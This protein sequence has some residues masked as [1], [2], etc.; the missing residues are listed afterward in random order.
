LEPG[1]GPLVPLCFEIVDFLEALQRYGFE[2]SQDRPARG[3]HA[4]SSHPNRF[5]TYWVHAYDD[6]TALF[7]WEFAITDLLQERGIQLGSSEALNL[8]M[9]PAQDERGPQEAGW[10]VAAMDR[11][12]ARLG[13]V[14]LADPEG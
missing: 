7:T 5:L 8:F 14:N 4:Y 1:A 10:L 6:G 13:S 12:E 9:F 11:A 2:A 3:A